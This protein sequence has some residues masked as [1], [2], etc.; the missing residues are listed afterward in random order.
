MVDARGRCHGA[1]PESEISARLQA[2]TLGLAPY[3]DGAS[4]RRTTLAALMQHAVP[5]LALQGV[6]TDGWLREHGGLAFVPDAAPAAFVS[7]IGALLAD[8]DRRAALS[9]AARTAYGTHMSWPAIADA[10]V[11]ALAGGTEVRA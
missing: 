4:A 1:L 2:A 7:T 9:R 3:A 10:Y 11:R 5:T 6:A 8:P